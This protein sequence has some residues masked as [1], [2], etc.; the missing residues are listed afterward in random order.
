MGPSVERRFWVESGWS[1]FGVTSIK[2]AS[3]RHSLSGIN[4][5]DRLKATALYR[6]RNAIEPMF[7][8]LK[9]FCRIA[10]RYNRMVTDYLTAICLAASRSNWFEAGQKRDVIA[11]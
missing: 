7:A 6:G 9:D 11:A 5:Q 10:A 1:A 3:Q 4:D 8:C 2:A